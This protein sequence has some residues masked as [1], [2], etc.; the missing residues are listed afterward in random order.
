MPVRNHRREAR[1]GDGVAVTS[2]E[3]PRQSSWED[4]LEPPVAR[5]DD[6][7]ADDRAPSPVPG[8]GETSPAYNYD[9]VARLSG[10]ITEPP[11]GPYRVQMVNLLRRDR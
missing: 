7:V 2:L 5:P 3:K 10:P 11:E 1:G 6:T 4:V 8:T 9:Q